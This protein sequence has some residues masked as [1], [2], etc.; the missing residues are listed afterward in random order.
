MTRVELLKQLD[1][2]GSKYVWNTFYRDFEIFPELR[3][4][5]LAW[6]MLLE[7]G[8]TWNILCAIVSREE[9]RVFVFGIFFLFLVTSYCIGYL[10]VLYIYLLFAYLFTSPSGCHWTR[11]IFPL[12]SPY[13]FLVFFFLQ[14]VEKLFCHDHS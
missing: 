5:L 6:I 7:V 13:N 8:S 12:H 11:L 2:F 10:M 4:L 1:S 14:T 9:D 3:S